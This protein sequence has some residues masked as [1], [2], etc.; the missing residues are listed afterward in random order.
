MTRIKQGIQTILNN[1]VANGPG[2][3]LDMSSYKS[4]NITVA[5]SGSTAATI[6]FAISNSRVQ[7]NFA[8]A[9]SITNQYDFVQLNWLN[10]DSSN[11]GSTGIPVTGTDI[12]KIFELNTNYVKWLCPI[13]SGYSAGTIQVTSEG[14]N[15]FTRN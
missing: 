15:D 14:V 11:P 8:I 2:V 3:P 9:S 7:P 5:T 6:K 12:V 10:N 13:I 4:I 1:A